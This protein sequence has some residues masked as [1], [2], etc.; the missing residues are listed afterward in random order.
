MFLF[1]G[2]SEDPC[3]AGVF[4]RLEARGLPVRVVAAPLAP[5]AQLTWRLDA[6]G[7]ASSLYPDVPDT[8]IA[9]VLCFSVAVHG[10]WRR[11]LSFSSRVLFVLAALALLK[12]GIWTD[13][14]GIALAAAGLILHKCFERREP[15]R[16]GA[17]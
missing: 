10:H 13:L 7:L 14:I 1:L 16:A 2:H 11:P 8:A 17:E 5:P 4:A 6:A 15:S 9:G 3:C 12:P